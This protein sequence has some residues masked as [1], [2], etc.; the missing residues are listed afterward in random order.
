MK[1]RHRSTYRSGLEDKV[2]EQ[3]TKKKIPFKYE[4]SDGKIVYQVPAK[5]CTY[6]PD[7]YITTKSGKEII[8]ESKGIWDYDDRYK[9]LLIKQQ[10]PHL[11]IRFVFTRSKSRI[12]KGSKTTYAQICEGNGRP[13][14]K[15][16]TWPYADKTIPNEWLEE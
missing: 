13:P 3:L 15:G 12:R 6:T 7:F 9:H 16:V 8:I 1:R 4:P 2:A 14:F 11:D 5:E 10:Y